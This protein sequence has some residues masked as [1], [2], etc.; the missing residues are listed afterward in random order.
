[1]TD[2]LDQAVEAF[3]TATNNIFS[4]D[5]IR[6]GLIAAFLHL[7]QDRPHLIDDMVKVNTKLAK[8]FV[9]LA[10]KFAEQNEQ[11]K[12]LKTDNEVLIEALEFYADPESYWAIMIIGDQPCGEFAEDISD[13]YE[14]PA[15]IGPRPGKTAR[16][17]LNSIKRIV[18]D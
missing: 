16:T 9:D 12:Q 13:D 14:H 6:T 8:R 2:N 7:D 10:G 1:L 11:I 18:N 17:A 3:D 15:I 5:A 4:K